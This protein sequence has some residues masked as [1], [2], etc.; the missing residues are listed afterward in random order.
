MSVDISM[1]NIKMMIKIEEYVTIEYVTI[2]YVD[3]D[4][5]TKLA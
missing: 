2:E 1:H 3:Y 5:Y 4:F